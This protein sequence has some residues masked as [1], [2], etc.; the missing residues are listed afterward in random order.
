VV[1]AL[2]IV[3]R[4]RTALAAHQ[5]SLRGGA[6]PPPQD[7]PRG[8]FLHGLLLPLSL[9]A[10]TIRSP[11][12][13]GP[14]LR[15]ATVR[16]AALV[17]CGAIALAS[18]GST[19][20]KAKRGKVHVSY[21][22]DRDGGAGKPVEVN[23][24]GLH[25]H[26]EGQPD[27]DTIELFGKPVPFAAVDDDGDVEI[28]DAEPPPEPPATTPLGRWRQALARGWKELVAF[29]GVLSI[30]E[31][32]LAFFTRRWDDWLSFYLSGL[33]GIRP[34]SAEPPARKVTV[35]VKWLRRKLKRKIRGYI[36]IGSGLPIAYLLR[37]IPY[38]GRW[39]FPIVATLWAWYWVGVFTAAKSAHAWADDGASPPPSVVRWFNARFERGWW[40]WPVRLY[41]RVWAWLVRGVSAA[42]ATFDRSPAPFLGLAL[43]RT[44][45]ALPG[46]YTLARPIVPVAAGR[47]CAEA[48][49]GNRFVAEA[50]PTDPA[51]SPAR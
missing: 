5:A 48:D 43:A 20:D 8:T 42:A 16:L 19:S 40:W 35:D 9:F 15:L 13:R 26:I 34:E 30:V 2:S 7:A 12:L 6:L 21:D 39:L 31:G 33:A 49:P 17:V 11:L 1:D 46:L 29:V 18:G 28:D 41:G 23:V 27:A 4:E 38:V 25:V 37:E 32:V 45:L 47:L 10:A 14:Y 44:I 50:A 3:A 22:K 36:I 24:P 51:V